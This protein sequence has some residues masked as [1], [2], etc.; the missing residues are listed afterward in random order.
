MK[1]TVFPELESA[2][3][4]NQSSCDLRA[5][6]VLSNGRYWVTSSVIVN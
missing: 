1:L 2:F 3:G 4:D 5:E 6:E